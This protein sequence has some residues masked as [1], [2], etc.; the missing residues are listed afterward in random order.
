MRIKGKIAVWFWLIL[1][2]GNISVFYGFFEEE[3]S[4]GDAGGLWFTLFL[5]NIIC[6]PL[7]IRN[8]VEIDGDKLT[9]VLGFGRDSIKIE[10]ITEVYRTHNPI[11]A[12]ALSLDRVVIKGKRQEMMISVCDKEQ[13][14]HELKRRNPRIQIR[15]PGFFH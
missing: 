3:L 5:L 12:G 9:L 14:F 7:V 10:D 4:R 1:I 8:Y 2:G 11:A 6:L 13:L 15:D